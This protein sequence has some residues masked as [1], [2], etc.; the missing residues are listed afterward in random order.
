M[1]TKFGFVYVLVNPAMNGCYKV[2][3][4]TRS[5]TQRAKELS[6]ATGVPYEF[7][8]AY[9]AEV[10][11]PA[12]VERMVHSAL[13]Y[14]RTESKEFF[15]CPLATIIK[16]IADTDAVLTDYESD[17]SREAGNPGFVWTRN[18]LGFENT[19]YSPGELVAL[20]KPRSAGGAA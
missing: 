14:C 2:G 9:Y 8:I 12:T 7:D 15:R 6:R 17:Y 10:E 18:P 5:P 13:A 4:T 11:M 1:T 19:L 3:M 16:T 20:C